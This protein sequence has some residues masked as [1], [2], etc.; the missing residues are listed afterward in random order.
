[1]IEW[2]SS[3]AKLVFS[4]LEAAP[5]AMLLVSADGAIAY[6]N[7]QTGR[8]FGYGSDELIGKPIEVLVPEDKRDAHVLRRR[9]YD[10]SPRT[11][12]MGSGFALSGR[13]RDGSEFPADV[14]LSPLQTPEWC[15]IIASVRDFT[16][17][18]T[19]RSTT[20]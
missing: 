13:R 12:P 7:H 3:S 16:A 15:G 14:S 4:V 5:D 6:A 17:S 20:H 19:S 2:S 1:V 8:L 9:D 11:R 18:R 10:R